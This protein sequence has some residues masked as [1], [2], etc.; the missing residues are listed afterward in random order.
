MKQKILIVSI[1]A[2]AAPWSLAMA[3]TLDDAQSLMQ[4]G[5]PAQAYEMLAPALTEHGQD[6]KYLY[7]AAVAALDG[8]KPEAAIPLFEQTLQLDPENG[9]ALIDLGRAHFALG[10]AAEAKARFQAALKL[11][12]PATVTVVINKYLAALAEQERALAPVFRAFVEGGFGHDNNINNATSQSQVAVPLFGNALLTLNP[13]SVSTRASYSVVAAGAEAIKPLDNRT[14]AYAAVSITARNYSGH[15]NFDNLA[16]ELRGGIMFAEGR[17]FFRIGAFGSQYR[18]D[19]N[20]N[21]DTLGINGDWYYVA[22]PKDR[23]GLFAQ[24]ADYRYKDVLATENFE[25]SLLGGSWSHRYNEATEI[26]AALFNARESASRRIDGDK[27]TWAGRLNLQHTVSEKILISG[28]LGYQES[29]YERQNPLFLAT[30]HDRQ[31]DVSLSA[32]YRFDKDWSLRGQ[33]A[34][35]DNRSNIALNKFDRNDISFVVRR[36]F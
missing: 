16:P 13:T 1:A 29:S 36:D 19:G 3:D 7:A 14:A 30:R 23:A 25:Q 33:W 26:S 35:I 20:H 2:M 34:H 22:S 31:H 12:P 24:Y 15:G 27:D 11:A 32:T 18:L 8:G 9:G 21:R 6:G 4:A 10:H 5:K 28:G 17:N